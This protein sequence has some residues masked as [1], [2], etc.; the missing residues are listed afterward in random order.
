[1]TS[2]EVIIMASELYT[3][4]IKTRVHLIVFVFRIYNWR[5][6]AVIATVR[7]V[8]HLVVAY[9]NPASLLVLFALSTAIIFIS[10]SRHFDIWKLIYVEKETYV[11][12]PKREDIM[13]KILYVQRSR[14]FFIST[15]IRSPSRGKF[16]VIPV[17]EKF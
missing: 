12:C 10:Q 17:L 7:L 3:A 13:E 9:K 5:M 4:A 14:C 8:V 1:M 16:P 6:H 2:P 15:F 11:R